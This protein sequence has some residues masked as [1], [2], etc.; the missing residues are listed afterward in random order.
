MRHDAKAVR[1][2][3]LGRVA[4]DNYQIDGDVLVYAAGTV[5]GD[6]GRYHTIGGYDHDC[7]CAFGLARPGQS[8]THTH[9]LELAA[10]NIARKEPEWSSSSPSER[11]AN[12]SD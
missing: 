12:G 3:L 1:L 9:A 4:V 2:V 7:D 10:W 11:S 5:E 6:H 8:H